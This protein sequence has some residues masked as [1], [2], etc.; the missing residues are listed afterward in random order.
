MTHT[1]NI[2]PPPLG[3]GGGGGAAFSFSRRRR[4][5]PKEKEYTV[6]VT[7]DFHMTRFLNVLLVLTTSPRKYGIKGILRF[8]GWEG[9]EGK[10]ERLVL[11]SY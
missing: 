11:R 2:I 10:G 7:I 9:G 8:W 5:E 1:K 4:I 6:H 3:G